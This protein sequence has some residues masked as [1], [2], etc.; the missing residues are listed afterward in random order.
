MKKKLP[1]ILTTVGILCLITTSLLFW[2]RITPR[3]LSF[4]I[5]ETQFTVRYVNDDL[6]PKV[7]II[8]DLDIK[9][10]IVP[11]QVKAGKWEASKNG[12]SHLSSS[13]IPGEIGNSILYGHNWPNLLGNLKNIKPGQE[14]D[15]QF[16]DGSMKKFTVKFTQTV[17][18]EQTDILDPSDDRRITLY[19]CTGFL[20]NKRFVV[21]A[22]TE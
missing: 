7:L 22:M 21:T 5:A 13:P 15:I 2:Q 9:L 10:S 1:V 4:D 16:K 11:V 20:D 19:T 6:T 17:S 18:P 8:K 14:I 12:V 3:R